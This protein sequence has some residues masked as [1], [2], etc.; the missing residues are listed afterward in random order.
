MANLLELVDRFFGNV[1]Q[2]NIYTNV[3]PY[4]AKVLHSPHPHSDT[5]AIPPPQH[6]PPT[7]TRGEIYNPAAVAPPAISDLV[8]FHRDAGQRFAKGQSFDEIARA[9]IYKTPNSNVGGGPQVAGV[10]TSRPTL[11]DERASKGQVP[12]PSLIFTAGNAPPRNEL[13]GDKGIIANNLYSDDNFAIGGKFASMT[14]RPAPSALR[15]SDVFAVAHWI[16]N[17]SRELSGL[18]LGADPAEADAGVNI[19]R[20]IKGTTFI[21]SQFLLAA[22]NP[23]GPTIQDKG[24]GFAA[25]V[26]NYSPANALWNPLALI[27]AATAR[28]VDPNVNPILAAPL[29]GA[30]YKPSLLTKLKAGIDVL[31]SKG[32]SNQIADIPTERGS[33]DLKA[34]QEHL[35]TKDAANASLDL[36]DKE[37]GPLSARFL[38]EDDDSLIDNFVVPEGQIYL[39]FMFQDLREEPPKFLYFRAFLKP[40]LSEVF[41]PDWQS[42][43]FYGRV[44]QVPI[45]MGTIRN[46]NV[47]F[48]VV[49]WSPDDLPI[50]WR[51]LGKLQSMVYPFYDTDG[52][53]KSAPII[54]M[55]IGD[56]FAGAGKEKQIKGLPGYITSMDWSYDDGIWNIEDDYRVPRKIS[57]TLGYTVLHDGNPGTYPLKE[58]IFLSG[59]ELGKVS[60]DNTQG[61]VF[62]AG[63][64]NEGT[65][66]K[67]VKIVVSPAEIRKIFETV[68][69]KGVTGKT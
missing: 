52:F 43:R 57:V 64:V 68:R 25:G 7:Q 28:V 65:N 67:D 22:M 15:Y 53:Y 54:K 21:A 32:Q 41:T 33:K 58:G 60:R 49:A 1:L 17:I 26:T 39:P 18:N 40:G 46:L 3:D 11:G 56:L 62:G 6:G 20:T 51:K 47:A 16:R 14:Q 48:D 19:E 45:Y 2:G 63:K 27:G 42:E 59:E 35:L 55:R 44:D 9:D 38:E 36:D 31:S 66:K 50:I 10:P 13:V 4:Q 12:A 24:L 61:H 23:G 5:R 8:D 69:N 29:I 30:E 37:V 34:L